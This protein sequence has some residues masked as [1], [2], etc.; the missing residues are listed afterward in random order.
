MMTIEVPDG[1]EAL[2]YVLQDAVNQAAEG[3]GKDRHATGESF[4]AQPICNISREVGVGFA[5]GQAIKKTKES[6]RLKPDAAVF[7]LLGAINYLA[8]AAIVR[9]EE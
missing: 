1:Y 9:G 5:L 4:E 2:G 3:K 8:A 7:E 6:A